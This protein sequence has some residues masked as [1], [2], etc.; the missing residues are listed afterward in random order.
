MTTSEKVGHQ[1]LP[2]YL[3]THPTND[4]LFAIYSKSAALLAKLPGS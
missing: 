3:Q 2:H 1:Q 4:F